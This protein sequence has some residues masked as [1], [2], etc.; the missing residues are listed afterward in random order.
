MSPVKTVAAPP[1]AKRMT[2]SYQRPSRSEDGEMRM[3]VLSSGESPQAEGG[4]EP[5]HDRH[6][7]RRQRPHPRPNEKLAHDRAVYGKRNGARHHRSRLDGR[8]T[9]AVLVDRDPQRHERDGGRGPE[10]AGEAL[11]PQD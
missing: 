11:G 10:Q 7:R 6:Q 2:Y 9:G 5:G 1:S 4:G 3:D 8:V